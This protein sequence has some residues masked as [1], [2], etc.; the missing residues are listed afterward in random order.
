MLGGDGVMGGRGGGLLQR[1]GGDRQLEEK[2]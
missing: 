2:Q 1:G